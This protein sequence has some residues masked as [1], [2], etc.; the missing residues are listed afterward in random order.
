[1][2]GRKLSS[3]VKKYGKE[4]K[5]VLSGMQKLSGLKSAHVKKIK[6]LRKTKTPT[7]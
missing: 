2:A 1:M 7:D 6:K 4:G 5:S 3:Y